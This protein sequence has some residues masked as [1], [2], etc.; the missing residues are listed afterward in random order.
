MDQ[1]RL[2]EIK[3]E[4][5]DTYSESVDSTIASDYSD[6]LRLVTV[7]TFDEQSDCYDKD[8]E[9]TT[10]DTAPTSLNRMTAYYANLEQLKAAAPTI[11]RTPPT[12]SY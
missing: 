5:K 4:G 8:V 12:A 1:K 2:Y 3:R 9:E 10:P 6:T 7:H 11:H